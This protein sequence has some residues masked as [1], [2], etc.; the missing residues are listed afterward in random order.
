MRILS[1]FALVAVTTVA[2]PAFASAACSVQVTG[3]STG[4]YPCTVTSGYGGVYGGTATQITITLNVP[5]SRPGL[6]LPPGPPHLKQGQSQITIWRPLANGV[7]YSEDLPP[8]VGH[9]RPPSVSVAL[10]APDPNAGAQPGETIAWEAWI[11]DPHNH[12]SNGSISWHVKRIGGVL[13]GGLIA[14]VPL[15]GGPYPTPALNQP[16][17]VTITF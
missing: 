5:R 3:Y 7:T 11:N 14:T 16:Y 10:E 13:H 6:H 12:T 17:H 15:V 4:I 9:L 1:A 2:L 8:G